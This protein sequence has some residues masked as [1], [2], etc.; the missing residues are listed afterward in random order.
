MSTQIQFAYFHVS[1]TRIVIENN[2]EN[3][4]ILLPMNVTKRQQRGVLVVSVKHQAVNCRIIFEQL[5]S[6]LHTTNR[7]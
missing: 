7:Y 6:L 2:E 1:R 3:I 5:L 4:L